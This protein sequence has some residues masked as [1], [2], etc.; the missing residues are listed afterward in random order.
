[1][2]G[3]PWPDAAG[4]ARERR[5]VT[6]PRS[7]DVVIAGAGVIGCLTAYY[8]ALKGVKA[9]VV[10]ADAIASGASGMAAG[11]LTP[12]SGSC[13]PGL[14][15][16]SRATL[17]LHALL[18]ATLP[19]ESGMDY[20]YE[21]IPTLR[22]VFSDEGERD[23]REWQAS[24]A[25]EGCETE[26]ITPQEARAMSPWLTGDVL[27]VLRC[28]IEP[29]VDAYRFTVAAGQA[30]EKRGARFVTGRVIGLVTAGPGRACGVKLADGAEMAAGAVVLAMG[31]WALEAGDWLGYL[32]PVRPERGQMLHIAAEPG[33]E[34]A[35][36]VCLK[37]FDAGG[38]IVP[39]IVPKKIGDTII[40][41][42][43]EDVG[44]D[45]TTTEAG[46]V[47]IVGRVARLSERILSARLSDQTACLR[48][49]PADGK[50]YVGRAPGWDGVYL[51]TGHYS[52]GLHYG[53]LTG[54]ALAGMIVDRVPEY[55]ISALDPARITA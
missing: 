36:R 52:E 27:T 45:R 25:S 31:P 8:L 37:A 51:A 4:A 33:D 1:M 26:W 14:L 43:R 48:P 34:A 20:G 55:D 32:V 47:E 2:A 29:M 17:D 35:R 3:S 19:G 22:C 53:P 39:A 30:A 13:D 11:I 44:F 9:T 23:L 38:S 7:S 40:A 6:R 5:S 10:E 49:K 18:A 24:R 28:E 41:A 16:L 21:L 15:A 42:T 12:Y 46:R 54:A 50:P